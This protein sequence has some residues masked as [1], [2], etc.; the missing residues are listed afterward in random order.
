MTWILL[1]KDK[2]LYRPL[3]IF[4]KHLQG[5]I[6]TGGSHAGQEIIWFRLSLVRT[7]LVLFCCIISFANFRYLGKHTKASLSSISF[8]ASC[9]RDIFCVSTAWVIDSDLIFLG[10]SND[11]TA[12]FCTFSMVFY[13]CSSRPFRQFPRT[14]MASQLA[15]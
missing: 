3:N 15:Y 2:P 14:S 9:L 1:E 6:F 4:S 12:I 7:T 11:T 10:R 13:I 5:N 8:Q